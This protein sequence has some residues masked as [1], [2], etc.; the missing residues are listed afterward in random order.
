MTPEERKQRLEKATVLWKELQVVSERLKKQH[1]FVA[2]LMPG[3][4]DNANTLRQ[5]AAVV[6]GMGTM[7]DSAEDHIQYGCLMRRICDLLEP[8]YED[9]T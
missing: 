1:D 7:R 5:G 9:L 3:V 4:E 8:T 2:Q 6:L